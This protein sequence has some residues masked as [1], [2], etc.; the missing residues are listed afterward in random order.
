[1]YEKKKTNEIPSSNAFIL[2]IKKK[3]YPVRNETPRNNTSYIT[4][5]RKVAQL[6]SPSTTFEFLL[7]Y[8]KCTRPIDQ[9]KIKN[10]RACLPSGETTTSPLGPL[11]RRI[12]RAR[13]HSRRPVNQNSK[14]TT[15]ISPP[16]LSNQ[17]THAQAL[18]Y[19]RARAHERN[20]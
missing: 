11:P 17:R 20:V 15:R 3:N 7:I 12:T 19:T 18:Q 2:I 8:L 5:D 14:K 10:T 6:P 1:M 4:V 16:K 9:K 13:S